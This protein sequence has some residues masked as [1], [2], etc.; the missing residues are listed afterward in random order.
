MESVQEFETRLAEAVNS[1]RK[2]L[3]SR[4]LPQLSKD[5]QMMLTASDTVSQAL[6]KKSVFH[7]SSI[8][9]EDKIEDIVPPP[10]EDIPESR[11]KI[12]VIAARFGQYIAMLEYASQHYQFTCAFLTPARIS[13]LN[14]LLRSFEWNAL[15]TSS[16]SL[17]TRAFADVVR[18]FK[19]SGDNFAVNIVTNSISQLG[20]ALTSCMKTL[21]AL[22]M[23]QREAYKL[24]VRTSVMPKAGLPDGAQADN[25]SLKAIKKVFAGAMNGAPFYTELI[26]EIFAENS[27]PD[28]ERNRDAA[29]ARV[30]AD[31]GG[32]KKKK[33]EAAVDYRAILVDALRALGATA[34]QLV[35]IINRFGENLRICQASQETFFSKLKELFRIAFKM[36]AKEVVFTIQVVNPATQ[37]SKRETIHFNSFS[38]ALKKKARLLN[39]FSDKSSA[40]WQK[41]DAM[42]DQQLFDVLSSNISDLNTLLKQCGGIDEYFKSEAKGAAKSKIRGIK[43]EI[44]TIE[45]SIHRANK[46]RAEYAGQIEEKEQLK[47]LGIG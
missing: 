26:K 28:A 33:E 1:K 25:S 29:I 20:S 27:G 13:K 32:Q 40:A 3:D 34:Q 35:L 10:S 45:N 18:E 19:R 44:S 16:D 43:V 46:L 37:A 15:N 47:R 22:S 17:N 7:D 9:Y 5:L 36:P 30:N 11:E 4:Q 8:H 42:T 39:A 21:K 12:Y 2:E 23:F 14:A 31:G 38:E 6:I 41:L 24:N